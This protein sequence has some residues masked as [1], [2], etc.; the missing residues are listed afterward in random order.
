LQPVQ[1]VIL[2]D[3]SQLNEAVA[4]A[5]G[6]PRP[7]IAQIVPLADMGKVAELLQHGLIASWKSAKKAA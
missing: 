7:R 5:T 6:G 1:E 3:D 2:C 4:I